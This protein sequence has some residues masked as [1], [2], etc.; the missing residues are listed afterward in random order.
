MAGQVVEIPAEEK[1]K[2]HSRYVPTG[3]II[4]KQIIG[5]TA[6]PVVT[7]YHA[8]EFYDKKKGWNVHA[9]FSLQ[10]ETSGNIN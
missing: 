3:N 9:A 7:E 6:V 2:D 5:I 8:M 4:P 1:L 10:S